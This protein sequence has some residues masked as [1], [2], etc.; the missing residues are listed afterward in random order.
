M[1]SRATTAVL[2]LSGIWVAIVASADGAAAGDD[3]AA[4]KAKYRRPEAVPFPEDNPHSEAKARLGELLFFDPR[5]SRDDDISCATCHDPSLAWE[6]GQ[7]TGVGAAAKPLR[8]HTPSIL[9]LAW[10]ELYFW[11]GRA[12]SLEEQALGPIQS[13]VEMAQPLDELQTELRAIPGYR[14]AF[15]AAFP[16]AG[17]TPDTIAKAIATFERTVVSDTAPFDR[18][19][20]G[21]ETAIGESAK[22]GF[23]AFNASAGCAACHSG[24]SFTD[25]GFH[26]VGLPN[27][28]DL[29]RFERLPLPA[30]KFAFKTPGLRD[31]ARRAPY[32]HDGSMATLDAVIEHY[33]RGMANRPSLS[34]LAKP[35]E[36]SAAMKTDLIAFLESLSADGAAVTPPILPGD[37]ASTQ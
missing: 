10:G 16:G 34:P 29:G 4:L 31:I 27:E 6:D 14:R 36:L 8:R 1:T 2:L 37:E 22:R 11:D 12:T 23:I 9:N 3:L 7:P 17:I 21:D 15:E 24:W 18:W 33:A 20:E 5:L 30:M 19:I 35:F 25:H 13:D 26:D 32:M 28:N